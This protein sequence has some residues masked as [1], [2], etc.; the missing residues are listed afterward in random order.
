[1]EEGARGWEGTKPKWVELL[2]SSAEE[3]TDGAHTVDGVRPVGL[4]R[5]REYELNTRPSQCG[6]YLQADGAELIAVSDGSLREG[7]RPLPCYL[8]RT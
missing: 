7:R 8:C 5:T 1:M 4:P 6:D 3:W 2:R